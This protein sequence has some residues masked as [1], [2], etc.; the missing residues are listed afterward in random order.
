MRTTLLAALAGAAWITGVALAKPPAM[1]RTPAPI[2]ELV[3][4]RPFQ[5]DR[6]FEFT[7]RKEKP[8]VTAGYILVLKV[9]PA[10][11]YPRQTAEPVL[12]VGDTTA[13][14]VNVGYPSGHLVVIVPVAPDKLADFDLKKTLIWF[15]TPELPERCTA[16]SIAAE[17]DKAQQ[18][19]IQPVAEAKAAAARSKGGSQLNVTDDYELLRELAPLIKQYAPDESERADNLLTPRVEERQQDQPR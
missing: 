5:L 7:W 2:Q 15:G 1:P 11:L 10:L 4:A 19:G 18:A 6:G 17:R 13:Q 16:Q 14:R 3:Y 9:E 12:Y 8:L